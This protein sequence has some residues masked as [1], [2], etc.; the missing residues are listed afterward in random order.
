M[1]V[2]PVLCCCT[3]GHITA[4]YSRHDSDILLYT[5]TSWTQVGLRENGSHHPLCTAH[6]NTF[7]VVSHSCTNRAL[8]SV[9]QHRFHP[10]MKGLGRAANSCEAGLIVGAVRGAC[11]G[12]RTAARFHSADENP[13]APQV[14]A[15][16]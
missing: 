7:R 4:W 10:L 3:V 13:S 8:G 11:N 1:R 5:Q 6:L 12:L 14:A 16:D 2:E 15:K 9:S